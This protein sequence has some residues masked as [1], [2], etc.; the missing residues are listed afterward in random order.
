[1]SRADNQCFGGNPCNRCVKRKFE[2]EFTPSRVK[3]Q[4]EA[5]PK[6]KARRHS[7]HVSQGAPGSVTT[8]APLGRMHSHGAMGKNAA[9]A[10]AATHA[11]GMY[12]TVTPNGLGQVPIAQPGAAGGF[13]Y[14]NPYGYGGAFM[15]AHTHSIGNVA[16]PNINTSASTTSD[17]MGTLGL[18]MPASYHQV[19][20]TPYGQTAQPLAIQPNATSGTDAF[21]SSLGLNLGAAQFASSA[22]AGNALG[23]GLG[24]GLELSPTTDGS[25]PESDLP[26]LMSNSYTSS[27]TGMGLS[28]LSVTTPWSSMMD[29]AALPVVGDEIFNFSPVPESDAVQVAG[30]DDE[31]SPAAGL[32][33]SSTMYATQ[34]QLENVRDTAT[35]QLVAAGGSGEWYG[36]STG[37]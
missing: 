27:D 5:K 34:E 2:C 30:W 32:A 37:Y 35:R 20:V 7:M 24:L 36:Q 3:P 16:L 10:R 1:M 15:H 14:P 4:L 25:S 18:P 33:M 19:Q 12:H 22:P 17:L 21:S 11:T 26:S 23:L 6:P 28:A 8:H 29:R 31:P 13:A 9:H